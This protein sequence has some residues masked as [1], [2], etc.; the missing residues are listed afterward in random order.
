MATWWHRNAKFCF[1]FKYQIVLKSSSFVLIW[2]SAGTQLGFHSSS[3]THFKENQ[4]KSCP[5]T[6]TRTNPV[7]MCPPHSVCSTANP[8]PAEMTHRKKMEGHRLEQ[9]KQRSRWGWT[10]VKHHRCHG[11]RGPSIQGPL[12]DQYTWSDLDV[13]QK[14]KLNSF[15]C[16]ELNG[17]KKNTFSDVFLQ[18]Q[19]NK[20][21]GKSQHDFYRQQNSSLNQN[22]DAGRHHSGPVLPTGSSSSST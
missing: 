15:Q 4:I 11:E 21:G 8:P 3:L 18:T 2:S 20:S 13:G 9:W 1:L 17:G 7:C 14:N 5:M 12:S 16:Q 6:N 22:T 19:N 10:D